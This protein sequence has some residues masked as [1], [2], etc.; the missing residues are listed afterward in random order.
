[1]SSFQ[2]YCYFMNMLLY[3]VVGSSLSWF[4]SLRC[5]QWK[6]LTL[7]KIHKAYGSQIHQG[8]SAAKDGRCTH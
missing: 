1:M 2:T 8:L 5:Q 7:P 3:S 6:L 4:C